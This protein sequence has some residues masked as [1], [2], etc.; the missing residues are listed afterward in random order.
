MNAMTRK[1]RLAATMTAALLAVAL[2]GCAQQYTSAGTGV[3]GM[4]V[5]LPRGGTVTCVV[6]TGGG[7]SCD[8]EAAR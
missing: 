3:N 2:T 1:T 6:A 4:D 5:D 8:W 7:I